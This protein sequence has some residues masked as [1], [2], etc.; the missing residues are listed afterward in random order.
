KS[1]S[2]LVAVLLWTTVPGRMTSA[3]EDAVLHSLERDYQAGVQ[4][5]IKQ[6]CL[7]CHATEKHK[8][9]LDLERFKSFSEALNQPKV[10]RRV[11][12]QIT[13]GEMP[14]SEKPQPT[15]AE[16]EALLNWLTKLNA[17]ADAPHKPSIASASGPRLRSGKFTISAA[18][19]NY[20]AFQPVHLPV[21]PRTS[22]SAKLKN[23]VDAFVSAGL[24][25]RKL[26]MSPLATPRELVRRVSFDLLGLPPTPEQVA[27]FEKNPTD[28]AWAE[29][30]DRLLASPH[31][32]ERWGRH[33]LD[34]VR[35]AE[36]NGYERDGVKPNAWRYRDYVIE[37]FNSD[38]PYD[39]FIREQ[40]AGDEIADEQLAATTAGSQEWRD[41]IIATGFYRLHVWD[42]EPDSTVKAE[43][44]DLDDIMV[45]TSTA[46]MGLTIGCARCHDHKYDPISQTD[47]YSM[48]SFFRSIDGYGLQ[49]TGGG[50]RGTGKIQ[51]PLATVAELEKWEVGKRQRIKEA[52]QRL[53]QASDAGAR[54]RLEAELKKAREATPPFDYALAVAENGP[55][56]KVTQV[57]ARG[58]AFTPKAEVSP[59]FPAVLGLPAPSFSGRSADATTTGRRRVLADWIANPQNPLTARVM[60]NRIWQK[61]FGVGIVPTPD[62]FGQMGERPTNQPLLDY[63]ASEFV[64]SGWSMKHM[65]KLIMMSR[66]YR[67]SSRADN[68]R[69][70]TADE[71]NTLLWRQNLRRVEA[72]VVRD[73]MLA[74][75]GTLNPKRGGPSVFPTLPKEVHGTQ[76]SSG[77]GWA[78]SP[79][80]EQNR[81]S[82]Y[83]VVKRALKVPLLECL[84]FANS[85]SP[86][87]VRPNTTTAPQALML[88][89]DAFVQTQAAALAARVTREGGERNE[90]QIA[91]AFQLVLQRAPTKAES[92]AS[93]SLLADQRK[94]AIAEG[95]REPGSVALT[96]FCRGLLNVNEMIYVD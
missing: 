83:L 27:T 12:E 16:R 55:K 84:D 67:M 35:Y 25:A 71:A 50:G 62:D 94:R 26:S 90:N 72:E 3:A 43:F 7:G 68:R 75:S 64:A 32:G 36:S 17:F 69:A 92:K 31:Y 11:F 63:L 48:L 34:L 53:A 20:W 89:N 66:A 4:P 30:I 5:V 29:L 96:S 58:D 56:P 45:A 51:R 38:K 76:D 19:Q 87:G 60:V 22:K 73:T 77:K 82:V 57:L 15:V 78:D 52:E 61:H 86:V 81:R 24:E 6:Y 40:L 18:D 1:S 21:L 95:A 2:I 13:E 14:P 41:A 80:G 74:V 9:D 8:G 70:L 37:A 28:A 39:R 85:A 79:A 47:Y 91:R 65:H 46:F 93:L 23:P 44:D 33:W 88:L 54:K 42:D 49:H 10:W 59:A